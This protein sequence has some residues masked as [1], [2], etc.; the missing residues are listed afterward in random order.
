MT[1]PP[2]RCVAIAAEVADA[3]VVGHDE[4]EVGLR[5]GRVEGRGLRVGRGRGLALGGGAA[6]QGQRQ[7]QHKAEQS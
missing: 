2:E 4:Q 6:G 5:R 7:E 3:E 1:S